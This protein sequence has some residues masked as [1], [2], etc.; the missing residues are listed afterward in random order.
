M[1][2]TKGL[3]ARLCVRLYAAHEELTAYGKKTENSTSFTPCGQRSD[4]NEDTG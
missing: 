4:T 1:T 3:Y 2:S